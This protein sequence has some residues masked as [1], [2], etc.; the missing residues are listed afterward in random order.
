MPIF[1]IITKFRNNFNFKNKKMNLKKQSF[2]TKMLSLLVVSFA[3]VSTANAEDIIIKNCKGEIIAKESKAENISKILIKT[4]K[5]TQ[6][7]TIQ[8]ADKSV[9]I[10]FNKN[11]EGLIAE[12]VTPGEWVLCDSNLS[13]TKFSKIVFLTD[14]TNTTPIL[15][16]AG[17]A[18]AITGLV[19][20]TDD[21]SSNTDNTSGITTTST[22][23]AGSPATSSS[24][25]SSAKPSHDDA[26][27]DK[28]TIISQSQLGCSGAPEPIPASAFR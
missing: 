1:L 14:K 25:G 21:G 11:S 17:T 13:E 5:L 15:T 3:F 7:P 19:L 26:C 22:Q 9:K 2:N 6:K 4:N 16:I 18:A 24:N 8:N 20:A 27:D 23:N 28:N 12:S 10:D